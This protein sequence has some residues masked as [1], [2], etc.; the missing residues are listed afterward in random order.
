MGRY[1]DDILQPGE[2]V[3]YSTNAH[4]VFYWPAIVAWIVAVALLIA[5][6]MVTVDSL[7]L[8]CLASAAVVAIAALYW[9]ATAWFHRWTTETDVTNLRVVHK[10]GF[11]KRR[12][13]EMSL[14]KVESVDVNQSILGR[15]LNYGDV[16]IRGVGEGFENIR[17]IAS[18]LAFRS[19]ITAR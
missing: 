2:K 4:W 8:A 14:D 9:S 1:I 10:T 18:P 11:I 12:T 15:L 17:T 13:F 3:L 16:T 5:S 7:T 19:S 6:R